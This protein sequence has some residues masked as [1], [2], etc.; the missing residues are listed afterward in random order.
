MTDD[1]VIISLGNPNDINR[2]DGKWRVHEQW[3]YDDGNDYYKIE[4]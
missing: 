3:V 1:M 4:Y 2:T